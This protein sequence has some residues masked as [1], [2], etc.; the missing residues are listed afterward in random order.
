MRGQSRDPSVLIAGLEFGQLHELQGVVEGPWELVIRH[1]HV[2]RVHTLEGLRTYQPPQTEAPDFDTVE[3]YMADARLTNSLPHQLFDSAL[4]TAETNTVRRIADRYFASAEAQEQLSTLRAAVDSQRLVGF[5]TRNLFDLV[6]TARSVALY[7]FDAERNAVLRRRYPGINLAT[8]NSMISS[9]LRGRPVTPG[10]IQRAE[11]EV[12]GLAPG[13]APYPDFFQ[14]SSQQQETITQAFIQ[15]WETLC[16][17]LHDTAPALFKQQVSLRATPLALLPVTALQEA[18]R[19]NPAVK[20]ADICHAFL[21]TPED[22]HNRVKFLKAQAATAA[23]LHRA[24]TESG[25]EG[26]ALIQVSETKVMSR[27]TYEVLQLLADP[28]VN[29]EAQRIAIDQTVALTGSAPTPAAKLDEI[30]DKHLQL[31]GRT[32]FEDAPIHH[33]RGVK[34]F[35]WGDFKPGPALRDR[36]AGKLQNLTLTRLPVTREM[37]ISRFGKKGEIMATDRVFYLVL[38]VEMKSSGKK[39]ETAVLPLFLIME[40]ATH[41]RIIRASSLDKGTG[42]L[43]AQ[44]FRAE[45]AGIAQVLEAYEVAKR[46]A[47]AGLP[48]HGKSPRRA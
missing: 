46:P 29:A 12:H 7:S 35:R 16:H 4:M 28:G 39:S 27:N 31:I 26:E 17:L 10:S 9:L 24:I 43:V 2:R 33:P 34:L 5:F 36:F 14:L 6:A 20:P 37:L 1:E 22:F 47:S 48:G 15:E 32:Y 30:I 8:R 25:L 21:R 40:S 42:Q 44:S 3:V 23:L 13:T 19:D 11:T 45:A 41:D 38:A 18:L